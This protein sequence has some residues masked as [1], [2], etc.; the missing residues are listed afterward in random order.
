MRLAHYLHPM[1]DDPYLLA[2]KRSWNEN[3]V[4]ALHALPHFQWHGL[5]ERPRFG[6]RLES[7]AVV[8]PA[9]HPGMPA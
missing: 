3:I 8:R 1:E 4:Q 5:P 2:V 9:R 7:G 6:W